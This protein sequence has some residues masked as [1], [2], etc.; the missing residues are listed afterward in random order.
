MG[1]RGSLMR[2]SKHIA[3]QLLPHT[4]NRRRM[5]SYKI[6]LLIVVFTGYCIASIK[7]QRWGLATMIWG[8]FMYMY[9]NVN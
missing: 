5:M 3:D 8:I 7:E 2:K 9:F 1:W 6:L 4:P